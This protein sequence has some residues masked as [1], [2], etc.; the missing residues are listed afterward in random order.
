MHSSAT[1]VKQYLSELP[2][3]RREAVEALRAMVL[4]NLPEGYVEVMNW[5]MITYEI[6]LEVYPKTYNKEPLMYA[7]LASQKNHIGVYLCGIYCYPELLKSFKA[8]Y[9][10]T[11]K[12]LD[13]G[14]SCIRGKKLEDFDLEAIAEVVRAVPLEQ[15]LKHYEASRA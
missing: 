12:K 6:P 4:K 3:D 15:Y 1:T 8:A 13:M 2:A 5:G 7:A 9:A 10:K 14:K 11:G